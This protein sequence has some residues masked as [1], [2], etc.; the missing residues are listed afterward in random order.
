M[1]LGFLLSMP[2]AQAKPRPPSLPVEVF[3]AIASNH[4][5]YCTLQGILAAAGRV[6]S[7]TQFGPHLFPSFQQPPSPWI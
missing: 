3:V 1:S 4:L 2:T 6:A 5:S 7:T